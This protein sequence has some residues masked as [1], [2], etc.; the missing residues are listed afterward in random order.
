MLVNEGHFMYHQ[1]LGTLIF[2]LTFRNELLVK[3]LRKQQ[4]KQKKYGTQAPERYKFK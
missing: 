3:I 1:I 4:Q 2:L